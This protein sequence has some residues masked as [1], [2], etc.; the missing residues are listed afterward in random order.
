MIATLGGQ[1]QVVTFT[2]DLLLQRGYPISEVFILHPQATDERL[3]HLIA[4]LNA[5]FV[6]DYYQF[7][8]HSHRCRLRSHILQLDETPLEDIVD[9]ISATGVL[10]TIHRLVRDLK[11][12]RRCI[13]LSITGGRRLMS[14]LSISAAHLHFDHSDHIWHI[15]TPSQIRKEANEGA[16]MH[17]PTEAGVRLIGAPFVPWGTYIPNLPQSVDTAQAMRQTQTVHMDTQQRALCQ[18][19]VERASPREREVL[20]AFARGLNQQEVAK[21]LGITTRTV[22]A[23]K[24][25]LLDLCREIWNIKTDTRLGYHFLYKTFAPYFNNDDYTASV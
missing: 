1:P 19:V 13:H 20:Q 8:D 2:L 18:R 9:D 14:L 17:V 24:T 16:H 22:D 11:Q 15:H 6:G 12:Q 5:E 25:K 23:H 7:R 4:L 10:D 21:A 3:Q